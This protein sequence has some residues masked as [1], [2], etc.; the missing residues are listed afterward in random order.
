MAPNSQM[1]FKDIEI[2]MQI[3]V[4]N[5]ST[6]MLKK[7]HSHERQIPYDIAYIWKLIC[8]TNELI[9]RK[10]TNSWTWRIDSWLPTGRGRG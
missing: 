9:Y 8:G 1:T 3:I 10:E 6:F 5:N 2:I 7:T 4:R